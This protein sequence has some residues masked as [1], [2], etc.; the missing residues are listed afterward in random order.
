M[1]K[2]RKKSPIPKKGMNSKH[3]GSLFVVNTLQSFAPLRSSLRD[4]FIQI[5]V[6]FPIS[7][8]WKLG[9]KVFNAKPGKDIL[10][11]THFLPVGDTRKQ[12]VQK[13]FRRKAGNVSHQG[14]LSSSY[15]I[16]LIGPMQDMSWC[17]LTSREPKGL[18]NKSNVFMLT[19][20][21]RQVAQNHCFQSEIGFKFPTMTHIHIVVEENKIIS[22]F[23]T[24]KT[25]HHWYLWQRIGKQ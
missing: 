21:T 22:T 8:H 4:R 25:E 19:S 13:L 1:T 11:S 12:G 18:R 24:V 23:K 10:I 5:L 20:Q 14:V 15:L 7:H 17:E 2:D 16:R 3:Q 6:S 9:S